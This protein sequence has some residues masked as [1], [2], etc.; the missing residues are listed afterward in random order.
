M[1]TGKRVVICED[2]GLILMQLRGLLLQ[3]RAQVV[4][5]AASADKAVEVTLRER[6]DVVLMDLSL[7]DSDGLD[8]A[9]RIL[10]EVPTRVV[11]LTGSADQQTRERAK[12]IGVAGWLEKPLASTDLVS[13]IMDSCAE[14]RVEM[15]VRS[16]RSPH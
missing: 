6:P 16:R 12:R 5:E 9:E 10:A 15:V 13:C 2:E 3:E 11:V 7:N 14:G 8:A 4:G 1:L